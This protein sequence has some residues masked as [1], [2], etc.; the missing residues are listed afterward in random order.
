MV[1]PCCRWVSA[2]RAFADYTSIANYALAFL[3][4][5]VFSR[6]LQAAKLT[7]FQHGH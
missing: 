4:E 5:P 3:T 1:L 7:Y 6:G 2:A